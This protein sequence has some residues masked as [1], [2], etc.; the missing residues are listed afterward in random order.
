MRLAVLL[1]AGCLALAATA[2]ASTAD[3]VCVTK[4]AD[5]ISGPCFD[6]TPTSCSAECKAALGAITITPNCFSTYLSAYSI[7]GAADEL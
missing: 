3:G 2:H 1:V 7:A 5:A 4:V 6:A